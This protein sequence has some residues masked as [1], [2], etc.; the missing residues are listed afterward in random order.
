MPVTT[1]FVKDVIH[2]VQTDIRRSPD[3]Y[4][5]VLAKVA[6]NRNGGRRNE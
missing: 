3:L 1:E 5:K 6:A 2:N 4:K